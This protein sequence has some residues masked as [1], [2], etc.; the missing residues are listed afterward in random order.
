MRTVTFE[1]L[2]GTGSGGPTLRGTVVDLLVNI[3]YLLMPGMVPSR[4]PLNDLLRRGLSHA[5]MSGGCRWEPFE[6]DADEWGE[7]R[8]A[9]TTSGCRYMEPPDWVADY[10]DWFAWLFDTLYGVPAEEHRR[11]MREDA[12]LERAI[13]RAAADDDQD[14]L[15]DLHMQRIRVGEQMTTLVTTHLRRAT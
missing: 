5:G 12:E 11:L 10:E 8:D 6:L 14:A 9:L 3:P 7:V 15:L 1:V 4:P 13:A 2:P